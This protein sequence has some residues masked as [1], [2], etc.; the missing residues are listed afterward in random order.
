MSVQNEVDE[1]CKVLRSHLQRN[2]NGKECILE[3]KESEYQWKQMEWIGWYFEHKAF[4]ILREEIGGE[5]GPK[6][7]NTDFDYLRNGYV[8]DFKSHV[9]NASSSRW[10]ILNDSEAVGKCLEEYG[11]LG[12]IVA[13]GIAEYDEDGSFKKWHDALKGK[14]SNYEKERI[15]RGAPSRKRKTEFKVTG[16]QVFRITDDILEKGLDS[17]WIGGFQKG[18]RN[19]DGSP[20]R[21]KFMIVLDEIPSGAILGC[22][23]KCVQTTLID[24]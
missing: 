4:Q 22:N 20:R 7:G 21:Q 19:A 23:I 15:K 16:F 17:R 18:M 2:W 13:R 9:D 5:R 8:W 11:E 24:N 12:F 3:L 10:T 14:K 1:I 6:Y